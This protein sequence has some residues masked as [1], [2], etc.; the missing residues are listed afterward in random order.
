MPGRGVPPKL[1]RGPFLIRG[2]HEQMLIDLSIKALFAQQ[3]GSSEA[4]Q[5]SSVCS[6]LFGQQLRSLAASQF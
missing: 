3:L 5:L 2:L 6:D 1:N 4:Q